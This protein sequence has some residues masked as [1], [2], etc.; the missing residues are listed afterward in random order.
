M[1]APDVVKTPIVEFRRVSVRFGSFTAVHDVSFAIADT[2]NRGEFITIIGPSGC[3]K[4]TVLNLIAGFL[5][6]T[7]GEVLVNGQP[8]SGPGREDR[9][10][11]V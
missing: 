7:E 10:S 11:V 4:S 9:K 2:P 1:S 3:G 5:R 8:I 6:P